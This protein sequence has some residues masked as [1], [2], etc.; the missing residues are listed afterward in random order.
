VSSAASRLL[1]YDDGEVRWSGWELVIAVAGDG[2]HAADVSAGARISEATDAGVV[3]HVDTTGLPPGTTL[4]AFAAAT[5]ATSRVINYLDPGRART[6]SAGFATGPL[7]TAWNSPATRF[8][9]TWVP[10][11]W[12]APSPTGTCG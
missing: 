3:V 5:C 12:G 2:D 10:G 11:R 7:S 1:Q 4:I 6:S 9:G 8:S